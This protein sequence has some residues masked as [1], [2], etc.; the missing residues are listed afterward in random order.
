MS[1]DADARLLHHIEFKAGTSNAVILSESEATATKLFLSN[2]ERNFQL[3]EIRIVELSRQR[4][5]DAAQLKRLRT[6]VAPHK[7]LPNELLSHIFLLSAEDKPS[8]IPLASYPTPPWTLRHVCSRWRSLVLSDRDLW[9]SVAVNLV[10]Y[11]GR[12]DNETVDVENAARLLKLILPQSGPLSISMRIDGDYTRA[13]NAVRSL[14][15]PYSSRAVNLSIG[16][17]GE[18]FEYFYPLLPN[19]LGSLESLELD[20]L[21]PNDIGGR[22]RGFPSSLQTLTISGDDYYSCDLISSPGINWDNITDLDLSAL[23]SISSSALIPILRRCKSLEVCAIL[24]HE[25][26][27][28]PQNDHITL[29]YLYSFNVDLHHSSFFDMFTLP[30]L[31]ELVVTTHSELPAAEIT[32]MIRRSEC[33]LLDLSHHCTSTGRQELQCDPDALAALLAA[34]PSLQTLDAQETVIPKP[35]L[36]RIGNR[37]LLPDL[38]ELECHLDAETQVT[39]LDIVERRLM[40]HSNGASNGVL[41][42]ALGIYPEELHVTD[43]T[44]ALVHRASRLSEVYDC[45]VRLLRSA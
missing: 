40:G 34:T 22:I 12:R 31:S 8:A 20:F 17:P 41:D 29:S 2:A 11:R 39:F 4:E 7:H 15:R 30:S 26:N 42:G 1:S 23:Y 14:I 16:L 10:A 27:R 13:E 38:E 9:N 35:I 28:G 6:A 45:S 43:D 21:T 3:L 18:G 24:V 36:E 37:E 19:H 33:V 25:R 32:A 5:Q 44:Q